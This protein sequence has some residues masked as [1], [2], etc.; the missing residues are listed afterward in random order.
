MKKIFAFLLVLA[1]LFGSFVQGV[2][3]EEIKTTCLSQN[4]PSSCTT[5]LTCQQGP[6]GIQGVNGTPGDQGPQ[7]IQGIQGLQG[8]QGI[9]GVNGTPGDQGPQG[10][11]GIQ[12]VNGTPGDPGPQGIQGI[13]GVPGINGTNASVHVNNTF[14]GLP[15]TDAIVT[16]IG[17]D[18]QVHLDFT[19]PQGL[20]NQTMNQTPNMT[21]SFIGSVFYDHNQASPDIAGYLVFNRSY[22]FDGEGSASATTADPGTEYLIKSFASNPGDPG[23]S[24]LPAGERIWHT[25]AKVSSLSGGNSYV[26]IRLFKRFTDGSEHELYNLQTPAL[27]L[28][29][30]EMIAT[31]L[32]PADIPMNTSDRFVVKYYA[33]TDA[34]AAKTITLYYDGTEHISQVSSPIS[35]GIQGP[36]GPQGPQGIP[37][38]NAYVYGNNTEV[39]YNIGGNA[40]TSPCL[41]F[42]NVTGTLTACKIFGDGFG[43]TNISAGSGGDTSGFPFL[44]GTRQYTGNQNYGGKVLTNVSAVYQDNSSLQLILN[45]GPSFGTESAVVMYGKNVATIGGYFVFYTP[46]AA[47][48]AINAVA[49][50]TGDT[51]S[52]TLEM[53]THKI[54]GLGTPTVSTDAATKGYVDGLSSPSWNAWTPTFTFTGGTPTG[55]TSTARYSKNNKTVSINVRYYATDSKGATLTQFTLPFNNSV[56]SVMYS[57]ES[58]GNALASFKDPG[59]DLYTTDPLGN[60]VYFDYSAAGTNGQAIQYFVSGTY[61]SV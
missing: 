7:G 22:P 27:S 57:R 19:I 21:S 52:P 55:V 6:P 1:I 40:T 33:K 48:N 26:V 47:K 18:T 36:P 32:T 39:L 12:G 5:N 43:I 46:N 61:E 8:I 14:T 31:K 15:G 60:A 53:N 59:A 54:T 38:T 45:A 35:Q 23:I 20:M 30:T 50:F 25:F 2:S 9:Q 34:S 3:I 37:G 4:A 49:Y 10:L 16:N 17:N 44:N 13:Q 42:D 58:Y 11:Q 29:T 56:R 28:S 24:A 51:D 41:K